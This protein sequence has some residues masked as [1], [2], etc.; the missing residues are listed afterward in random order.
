MRIVVF[1]GGMQGCVIAK[2]LADRPEKPEVIVSDLV[3]PNALP[4]GVK[5]VIADVT[6]AEQV[7]NLLKGADVAVLA[8]PSKI[9]HGALKNII[10]TGV[11][12]ADVCFTPDPPLDLA[13]LARKTGSA[14]IIDCGVAPGLSHLLIGHAYAQLGGLDSVRILVGGVPQDPPPAYKHAVYFNPHDLMAEYVRPARARQKGKDIE[15]HPLDASIEKHEDHELGQM[16]AFLSDGLRTLLTSY[17]DVPFMEERTLRWP[18]HLD[19][20]KM[21]REMGLLDDPTAFHA[22]A[23]TLGNRYP[24]HA[25]K[26]VLLMLVEGKRGNETRAWRLIDRYHD[27]MSAMSRTTAFTTAATA[28]VLARKQF[29]EPGVHPPE[30]LGHNPEVTKAMLADLAQHGVMVTELSPARV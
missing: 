15:P 27:G 3:K 28:M 24:S 17:K 29:S 16:E 13:E 18:G 1:G 22:I 12:V 14:C 4:E 2:N 5:S 21:L 7:K 9:A 6:D 23:G 10:E 19:T 26:D 30:D 11:P 8:V 25:N 20:M